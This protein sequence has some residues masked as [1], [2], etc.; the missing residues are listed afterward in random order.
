MSIADRVLVVDLYGP[1][2]AWG[3]DRAGSEH[4]D[5]R[6]WPEPSHLLGL[7]LAALGVP[8]DDHTAIERWTSPLTTLTYVARAGSPLTDFHVVQSAS[9][10][11]RAAYGMSSF[12]SRAH[13]LAAAATHPPRPEPP[14]LTRRDYRTDAFYR[15]AYSGPT[16]LLERVQ[17]AFRA[18]RWTLFLGRK[19]CPL[20]LPLAP[21]IVPRDQTLAALAAPLPEFLRTIP[22]A[23]FN[24]PRGT[25]ISRSTIAATR[26]TVQSHVQHDTTA[27][28]GEPSWRDLFFP[29]ENVS[30]A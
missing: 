6:L 11:A 22:P 21:R 10:S 19:S 26:R 7:A 5:S 18:P 27:F 8:R 24:T 9:R 15:A 30:E 12:L 2:A 4:R 17:E 29:V 13:Q 25:W 14:I 16:E 23:P 3:S 1:L 20:A 28:V